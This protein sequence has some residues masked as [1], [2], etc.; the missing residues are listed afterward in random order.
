VEDP[1]KADPKAKGAGK[2]GA[3]TKSDAKKPGTPKG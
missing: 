2:K 3:T 1:A